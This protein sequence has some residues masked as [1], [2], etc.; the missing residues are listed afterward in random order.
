MKRDI[1]TSTEGR[2]IGSGRDTSAPTVVQVNLLIGI[3]VRATLAVAR[4][5]RDYSILYYL[6]E[7]R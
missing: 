7:R 1:G 2:Y 5:S 3:N 6:W 4:Y